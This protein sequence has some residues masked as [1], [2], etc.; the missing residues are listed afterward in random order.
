MK[1]LRPVPSRRE[2]RGAIAIIVG[3]SLAVLI[4]FAGLA[5]DGGRLYMTK[6]ELQNAADACALAAAYELT[7]APN[8]PAA[9]FAHANDAGLLV[10][11]DNRV[12]FQG[13]DIVPQDVTVEF[14]TSLSAGPWLSAA[15]NPPGN[16]KYVRC[17]IQEAGIAPWF[18]Q[19]LGFG[20]QTVRALATATLAN[21]QTNCGIPLGM[22]TKGPAPT[23]GLTKGQWVDGRFSA[24]GGSTGSFNWIDFTPTAG[25]QSELAALLKGNGECNMNTAVNV[26]QP[27]NLGN[28]AA[29]AWNTRFGLYQSGQNN[30]NTAPP[31]RT[32]YA[33]TALNWP[34][35]FNALPDFLAKRSINAPYGPNVAAGNALTGLSISNAYNPT[36]SV[37]QHAQYGAD[38]RLAVAPLLNCADWEGTNH[39][40]PIQAWVCVLLLHPIASPQDIVYMEFEGMANDPTSPCATSGVI[41]TANSVGPLVPG[42]VQ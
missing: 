32:G 37:A 17:T 36:T 16:S 20:P 29:Q 15:S 7:G 27:G 23:Y 40:A 5:L 39:Q 4:G 13:D 41:G 10:A 12:G 11:G 8:I 14:G 26:G 6:T 33:Y 22:C 18:M 34:S 2:Q 42:L 9:N 25:G 30:V 35:R 19:V 3:L 24:G 1:T 21:S 28:A 38:R 31:D